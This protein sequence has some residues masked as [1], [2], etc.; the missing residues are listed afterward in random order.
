MPK[1]RL[2]HDEETNINIKNIFYSPF[3]GLGGSNTAR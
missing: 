3:R 1:Y 2:N